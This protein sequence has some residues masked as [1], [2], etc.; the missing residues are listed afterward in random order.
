MTTGGSTDPPPPP[1]GWIAEALSAVRQLAGDAAELRRAR[2]GPLTHALAQFLAA[3]YVMAAKAAVQQAGG[4]PLDLA[5]LRA[6][7]A[8]VVALRRGD[9]A[10]ARLQLDRER[11]EEAVR[12][13]RAAAEAARKEASR[14]R[15]ITEETM[16][17]IE[18]ELRLV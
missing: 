1:G 4:G 16:R 13:Q 14:P 17:K 3:Q 7:C 9:Q 6:L 15:G 10:A 18:E 5:A 8:D 12:E 2:E 11:F